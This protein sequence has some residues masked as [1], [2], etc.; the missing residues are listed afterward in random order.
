MKPLQM[1]KINHLHEIIC[2]TLYL[3]VYYNNK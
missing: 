1:N 2:D 3:F